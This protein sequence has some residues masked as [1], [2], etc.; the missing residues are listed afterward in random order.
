[1]NLRD[2]YVSAE[3]LALALVAEGCDTAVGHALYRVGITRHRFLQALY[4][5][6]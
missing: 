1:M 6:L 2:E 4:A 5:M 3:N